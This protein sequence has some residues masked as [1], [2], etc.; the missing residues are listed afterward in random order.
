M[1]EDDR[2]AQAVTQTQVLR[3]PKQVLATFGVTNINYYLLTQPAYAEGE[4][5]ET[6]VR[7]GRVVANCPR[8]GTP[9]YLSRL[10]GF[11][12]YANRYFQKI[13]DTRGRDFPGIYY[14]YRNEPLSM[15]IVSDSMVNV[16]VK[17][18]IEIDARKDPLATIIRGEDSLWDVSLMKFIFEMTN[19]SVGS[20][21]RDFRSRGLLDI[22]NGVP[23]EARLPI[24][25]MFESLKTGGIA[26]SQ[27]KQELEC[28]GLFEVYQDRF[29]S[30][31]R[32]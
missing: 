26:P 3:Q 22:E 10:D 12:S 6:V 21:L 2:L 19:A 7:K 29:L 13:I 4:S 1:K 9:F 32:R 8:I 23:A 14:T 18:N 27:L 5:T 30:L 11:S 28:W 15:D 16:L 24:E 31:F 20:N 25:D 17:I